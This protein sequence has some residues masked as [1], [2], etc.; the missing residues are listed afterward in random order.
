MPCRPERLGNAMTT[1]AAAC[2]LWVLSDLHL[3][4]PGDQCVFRAHEALTSLIDHLTSLP[5][6]DP[7]QWLV[8][9][10]DVFD[11]LQIPGYEELSLP[12]APQRSGQILAALDAEPEARNVVRALR[13]FTAR[14]H[15]LSCM[16]GNHDAELNLAPVQKLLSERLGSTTALPPWSGEWRLRVAGQPVVGRHGHHGDAFNAISAQQMRSAQADGNA[17][18]ALPPGSRLVLHVINPFRR[19]QT[20]DGT[21]RFPF[22]DSLPSEHAVLLAV[23]LLDPKLAAKRLPQALGIGAAALLRK[24]LMSSGLR[25][26]QLSSKGAME[27]RALD[28]PSWLEELHG[29]LGDAADRLGATS[30]SALEYEVDA[31]FAG[32]STMLR[33]ATPGMLAKPGGVRGLLLE[34]LSRCL[35]ESRTLFCSSDEDALARETMADWGKDRL[36]FAGHTHAARHLRAQQGAGCYINT[37]SWIDRVVPPASLTAAMMSDWLDKLR[38]GKVPLWN[39]HPVAMVDEEGARLLSWNG[40]ELLAWAEPTIP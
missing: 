5:V 18:V 4:P 21:A 39:G 33:G 14:G 11:Y 29:L 7:P 19:A 23:M 32:A 35:K 8:L 24:A 2:R 13:R 34:A 12:L 30:R 25:S 31:Y 20:A 38:Q 37:G 1:E 17:T 9:N 3:A 26:P 28:T 40:K 6:A 15:K 16:P 22:I 27:T 10:G 36:A